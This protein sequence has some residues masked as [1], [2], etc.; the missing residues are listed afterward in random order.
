MPTRIPS[1]MR[2][3]AIDRFGGPEVLK[4]HTLP[5]PPIDRGEVLIALHTSGVGG[6]DADMR[7]GWWPF[8]RPRFPIVLGTDGSGTVAALGAGVR[9]FK[10]G[11]KV[12]AYKWEIG[13]GGFYAEYVAVPAEDVAPIPR[14]LDLRHA[15]AIPVTGLTALQGLDDALHLKKGQSIIIHGASG[16]VG[17]MAVQ[18]AKLRGARVFA[19]ASGRDSVALVRRLG[20]DMAIDGQS[21]EIVEA[22]AQFAPGGVDCILAFTGNKLG[23]CLKALRRGGLLAY[24][25]GIEP[26]PRK[27]KGLKMIAYDGVAGVRQFE[28][29]NK[30]VEAARIKVPIADIYPLAEAA[31]AHQRLAAGHVLGKVVLRIR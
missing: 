26:A 14:P 21:G 2:A 16:G 20:A 11:E 1:T 22:A 7:A 3:A 4:I 24:P 19:T 8:G 31:R 5:V 10:V 17:T 6:W 18:F 23:E 13:K 30:A 29:L 27:R 28:R 12:Y 25:N 15:G 9:R